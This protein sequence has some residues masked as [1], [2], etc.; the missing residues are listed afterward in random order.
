MGFDPDGKYLL[1]VSHN[2]LGVFD[3]RTWQR[4]A[5]DPEP[6]YPK[7]GKV[8]GIGPLAGMLIPVLE[9]DYETDRLV[10]TDPSKKY[11]LSLEDFGHVQVR[12]TGT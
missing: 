3:T 4:V 5:R 8:E 10:V 6:S 7:N 11:E 9:K 2:G 1:A 12:A